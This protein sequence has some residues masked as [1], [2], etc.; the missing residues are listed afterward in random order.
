MNNIID[1]N[2][3]KA[4]KERKGI[5]KTSSEQENFQ[6]NFMR[7]NNSLN[8]ISLMMRELKQLGDNKLKLF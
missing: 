3:Y 5:T 1:F 4:S 8:K 6:V 7:I 2:K